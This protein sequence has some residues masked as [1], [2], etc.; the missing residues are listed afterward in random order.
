MEIFSL[1]TPIG[2]LGIHLQDTIIHRVDFVA[3]KNASE[4]PKNS[5]IRQALL[6]YFKQP[7][8]LSSLTLHTTGTDFQ[9]RVWKKLCT[10]PLGTTLSYND[11]AQQLK[12]S[13]RAVGNACRANPIPVIIPCHRVVA[14][15]HLGGFAGKTKGTMM[16]IK[17]WLLTHET[18]MPSF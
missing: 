3:P 16:D 11:I 15:K 14:K 10:I 6:A 18:A 17:Q 5:P 7:Q 4:L 13:P 1:P 12:T 2:N 9:K 8:S